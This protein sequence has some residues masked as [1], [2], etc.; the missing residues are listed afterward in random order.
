MSFLGLFT[1]IHRGTSRKEGV[2]KSERYYSIRLDQA[3]IRCEMYVIESWLIR[4][5]EKDQFKYI[6]NSILNIYFFSIKILYII[7]QHL[8]IIFQDNYLILNYLDA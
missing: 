4:W 7:H 2:K 3:F 5:Q 8:N 6:Y 1:F